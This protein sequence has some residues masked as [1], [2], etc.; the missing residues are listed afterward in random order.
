MGGH[1]QSPVAGPANS[2]I[3][4]T[5]PHMLGV[6]SRSDPLL[7]GSDPGPGF[8]RG[9]GVGLW[10]QE[11]RGVL[12]TRGIGRGT[13]WGEK[14]GGRLGFGGEKRRGLKAKMRRRSIR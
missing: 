8:G 13:E 3:S 6:S 11:K 12:L 7:S 10:E 14:R 4:L 2:A 9:W 5:C 1:I